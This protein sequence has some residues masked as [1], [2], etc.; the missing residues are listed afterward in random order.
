M[1]GHQDYPHWPGQL[2]G[3]EGCRVFHAPDPARPERCVC[4][5]QVVRYRDR[6]EGCDIAGFPFRPPR[7][8]GQEC[9]TYRD[10][11]GLW[12]ECAVCGTAGYQQ[13]GTGQ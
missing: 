8:C 6:R 1:S 13:E 10:D 11:D 5:G 4:G 2:P 7:C 3:C 12:I 9:E